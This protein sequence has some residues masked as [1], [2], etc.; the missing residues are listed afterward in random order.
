[1]LMIAHTLLGHL[2]SNLTVGAAQQIAG[3]DSPY[4]LCFL[5]MAVDSAVLDL[6]AERN[7]PFGF[8]R[9][10]RINEINA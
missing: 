8:N 5:R 2:V 1:M 4:K 6:I 7:F 9:L 10:C 3:E